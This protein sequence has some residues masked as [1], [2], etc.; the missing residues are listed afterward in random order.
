M[1]DFQLTIDPHY[2]TRELETWNLRF[3]HSLYTPRNVSWRRGEQPDYR[4]RMAVELYAERGEGPRAVSVKVGSMS[5]LP[6]QKP[7]RIK[8]V[9]DHDAQ[10]FI[11]PL[12]DQYHAEHL[13][14]VVKKH[15]DYPGA[16]EIEEFRYNHMD[17]T[18]AYNDYMR[19][20]HGQVADS[21]FS[22]IR[23]GP[24][25]DVNGRDR[26]DYLVCEIAGVH[27]EKWFG[28]Y[29]AD[30]LR[31]AERFPEYV[32]QVH[33]LAAKVFADEI[34]NYNAAMQRITDVTVRKGGLDMQDWYI[35]CKIDGVQQM[36]KKVSMTD[37]ADYISHNDNAALSAKYFAK[38]LQA[39]ENI[40]RGYRM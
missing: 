7:E 9:I 26:R 37:L 16:D 22:D 38:E 27:H 39:G 40:S 8:M 35:R 2:L 15:Q 20:K 13:K 28:R 33:D 17:M 10:D 3:E 36:G 6:D 24:V 4:E 12:Q 5:F 23:Q 34:R 29:N 21:L 14:E 25:W 11:V 31:L 30:K 1:K 32:Y 18:D 19:M